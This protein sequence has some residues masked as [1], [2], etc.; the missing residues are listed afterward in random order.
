MLNR[1]FSPAIVLRIF[2]WPCP[3]FPTTITRKMT[4]SPRLPGTFSAQAFILSTLILDKGLNSRQI[5]IFEFT[6]LFPR[7]YSIFPRHVYSKTTSCTIWRGERN[8]R[9][10]NPASQN[11]YLVYCGRRADLNSKFTKK[12]VLS[13]SFA[14][15]LLPHTPNF[16]IVINLVITG[17]VIRRQPRYKKKKK[18]NTTVQVC[19]SG[20]LP[21]ALQVMINK[22][23]SE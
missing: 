23:P 12:K 5:I 2:R 20:C 18:K 8:G 4:S 17:L 22:R 21:Q 11:T 7:S 3:S 13:R 10:V 15:S 6:K 19:G 9:S 1:L 14:P 16:D